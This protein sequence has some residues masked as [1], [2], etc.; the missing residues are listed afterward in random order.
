MAPENCSKITKTHRETIICGAGAE[1]PEQGSPGGTAPD[2]CNAP[3][4]G[5]RRDA[6]THK[7][8]RRLCHRTGKTRP[9]H[10]GT[11]KFIVTVVGPVGFEPTT[12]GP[13]FSESPAPQVHR[14]NNGLWYPLGGV[15]IPG[16]S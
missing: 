6:T 13:D 5:G 4:A 7:S 11:T 15:M 14:P 2:P 3:E 12:S 9:G 1:Q 10:L 8:L 16:P